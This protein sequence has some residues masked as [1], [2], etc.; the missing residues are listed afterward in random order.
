MQP[1]GFNACL[2]GLRISNRIGKKTCSRTCNFHLSVS[3]SCTA[4][5]TAEPLTTAI[6]QEIIEI[7]QHSKT[8]ADALKVHLPP[9]FEQGVELAQE[10]SFQLA[11]CA[12]YGS[13]RI[14]PYL[15]CLS[16]CPVAAIWLDTTPAALSL[17]MQ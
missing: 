5:C 12:T 16:Q 1:A 13:S 3:H 17:Y 14:S 7:L 6:T 8:S 10:S 15:D 11:Q 4:D 9:S 2:G